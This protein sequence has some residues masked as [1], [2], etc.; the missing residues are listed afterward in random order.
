MSHVEALTV[1]S[2]L[3]RCWLQPE[4]W[5]DI[6]RQIPDPK[7]TKP[8]DWSDEDDGEWEPPMIDNPEFKV[9]SAA[10]C[11]DAVVHTPCSRPLARC[12]ARFRASGSPR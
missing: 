10:Y 12:R 8:E 6:P 9:C 7:A 4:G 3:P 1:T 11:A 2:C 5:D